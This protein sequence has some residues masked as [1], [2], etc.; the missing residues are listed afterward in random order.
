[1]GVTVGSRVTLLSSDIT[2]YDCVT[3]GDEAIINH[4]CGAQ[5]H[6]FEDRIMKVG[7]VSFGNRACAKPYSICLPGSSLSDGAQL[8]CLSL[9]MKG[10]NLPECTAWEGAPVVPRKRRSKVLSETSSAE[11][12]SV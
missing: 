12:A 10:E 7:Q 8:G 3:I 11:T 9:L 2:E 1:M 4:S 6:L 5:T